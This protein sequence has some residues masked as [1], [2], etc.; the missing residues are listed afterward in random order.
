MENENIVVKPKYRLGDALIFNRASDPYA[1]FKDED[2]Q[3]LGYV[4]SIVIN[5]DKKETEIR[6]HFS[7]IDDGCDERNVEVRFNNAN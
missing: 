3:Q 1:D 2:Y 7:N 6:Y 4:A 5:I